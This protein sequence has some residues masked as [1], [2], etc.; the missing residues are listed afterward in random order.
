MSYNI[1]RIQNIS[2][3]V[4]ELHMKEFAIDEIY[5]IGELER[6][7]WANND[8]VLIAVAIMAF[9]VHNYA[10]PI[11]SISDQIDHLKGSWKL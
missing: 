8:D 9:C 7:L 3:E 1:V 11:V 4:Q 10:G 6:P 5:D 2:G